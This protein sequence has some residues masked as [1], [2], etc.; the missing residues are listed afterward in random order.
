MPL[1]SSGARMCREDG[2]RPSHADGTGHGQGEQACDIAFRNGFVPRTVAS[3]PWTAA[4]L[5]W[6]EP[7]TSIGFV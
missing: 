3:A 5:K 4:I 1:G 2:H 7:Y 6:L